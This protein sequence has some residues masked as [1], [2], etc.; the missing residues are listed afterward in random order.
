MKS[1][2][3]LLSFTLLVPAFAQENLGDSSHSKCSDA[4]KANAEK[5]KK[6]SEKT[7]DASGTVEG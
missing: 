4:R 1:L 2:L 6:E 5:T 3:V 7:K